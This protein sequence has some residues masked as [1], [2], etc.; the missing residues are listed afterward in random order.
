MAAVTL[1]TVVL[2]VEVG[3]RFWR[4][5]I[6][7][8][9]TNPFYVMHDD[10]LGWV[11][12]PGTEARHE[13]KEFDISISI[14]SSGFRGSDLDEE[15]AKV[16]ALGDSFT[17]GWGVEMS[18]TFTSQLEKIL[19]LPTLNLG[20]SGY[21]TDQELL[22]FRRKKEE[23]K[24]D[25]VLL[26]F[27][28]ND[29][30]EAMQQS[31]YGKGKPRF[32]SERN[33]LTLV[34]VP[35]HESFLVRYSFF[36]RFIMRRIKEFLPPSITPEEQNEG[37]DLVRRLIMAM[38]SEVR[39]CGA[40]LVLIHQGEEWLNESLAGSEELLTLDVLPHLSRAQKE[41]GPVSYAE[42]GHWTPLGHRVVA[43]AI[44]ELLKDL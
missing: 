14:N 13:T 10:T 20:V 43:E 11:Y 8:P 41:L 22:L 2:I 30:M 9:T 35:V 27:C 5:Q 4:V 18:E 34:N 25:V 23:L 19:G 24:P 33:D 38:A 37:R 16:V 28:R 7:G 40:R 6:A 3:L 15:T 12:R 17:F 31:V 42:D 32:T 26:T 44:A 36:Y 1:M 21:S 39:Q 29:V